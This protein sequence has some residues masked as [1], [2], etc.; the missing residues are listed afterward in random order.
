MEHVSFVCIIGVHAL[1]VFSSPERE[2]LLRMELCGEVRCR[3]QYWS[4]GRISVDGKKTWLAS[5]A[6]SAAVWNVRPKCA[7]S[8][9]WSKVSNSCF[10]LCINTVLFCA[11]DRPTNDI[12]RAQLNQ[13]SSEVDT[14]DYNLYDEGAQWRQ[15][16]LSRDKQLQLFLVILL[17][18]VTCIQDAFRRYMPAPH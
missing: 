18:P 6:W 10:L 14:G 15:I 12:R 8:E 16:V 5:C 11:P 9:H 2:V 17:V 13:S 7:S 4:F 1:P 3:S